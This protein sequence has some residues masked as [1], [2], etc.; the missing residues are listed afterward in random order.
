MKDNSLLQA[1]NLIKFDVN[2]GDNWSAGE[3]VHFTCL[4][5]MYGFSGRQQFAAFSHVPVLTSQLLKRFN[6]S[7]RSVSVAVSEEEGGVVRVMEEVLVTLL[8]HEAMDWLL[9][10][11]TPTRAEL[12]FVLYISAQCT[13]D[14]ASGLKLKN[15]RWN[16]DHASVLSQSGALLE[17]LKM[18]T[19][20][21]SSPEDILGG[22][23]KCCEG[24]MLKVRLEYPNPNNV[25]SPLS[26]NAEQPA[27]NVER[28]NPLNERTELSMMDVELQNLSPVRK[29]PAMTSEVFSSPEQPASPSLPHAGKPHPALQSNF[30]LGTNFTP[31]ALEKKAQLPQRNNFFFSDSPMPLAKPSITL[32]PKR[33]ESSIVAPEED[34]P[35]VPLMPSLDENRF[36]SNWSESDMSEDS[37]LPF[38]TS[39]RILN[40]KRFES[41]IF[42]PQQQQQQQYEPSVRVAHQKANNDVLFGQ[43]E[44]DD[45]IKFNNVRID[46]H[47]FQTSI[48]FTSSTPTLQGNVGKSPEAKH[49]VSTVQMGTYDSPSVQVQKREHAK[50][51]V[52]SRA[53]SSH[54]S[55]IFDD[56]PE[57]PSQ[58]TSTRYT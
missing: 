54:K 29:H 31:I 21:S 40:P 1:W 35:V 6:N 4:P 5:T 11:V 52:N 42:S 38:K 20:K 53:Y 8:H 46:P 39:T 23:L 47:R 22:S 24:K 25:T 49:Q 13:L 14:G 27:Q 15:V 28:R 7:A 48:D 43:G 36:K 19:R 30:N 34:K 58:H 45:E 55:S 9:P 10:K 51:A 2:K 18:V 41:H 57:S 32:D 50:Q 37:P 17:G 56:D 33:L 12:T 3:D 26:S 44:V 16:W